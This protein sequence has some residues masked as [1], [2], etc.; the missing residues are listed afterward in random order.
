MS[1][2]TFDLTKRAWAVAAGW[3]VLTGAVI[4]WSWVSRGGPAEGD[5]RIFANYVL[6]GLVGLADI[7]LTYR[8]G[9]KLV[10]QREQAAA[11]L[12]RTNADLQDTN[13]Q[14][15]GAIAR[16]NQMAVE[17]EVASAAKSEFL[18]NMSH[19]IR[20]P[21]NAIIGMT[22][23]ALD[24]RLNEDQRDYLR[25]VK[26]SA[27]ALLTIINDILDFS[28][29]EAGKL[30]LEEAPLALRDTVY[31]A[32]RPLALRA[33]DKGLELACHIRPDV[34]DALI[35]DPIRLRQ[36]LVNL[37]GNAIKFTDTGEVVV[38]A[39][40]TAKDAA[41]ARLAL[42]V[43]DTGVGIP[44]KKR[45]LIFDAFAQADGSSTR[46]HGGTG[47]GL[48]ISRK[49]VRMMGGDISVR[50]VP[51]KGSTFTFEVQMRMDD[52]PARVEGRAGKVGL[53]GRRV[54]IVD[55]NKTNRFIL[56]EMLT[57]W[58]MQ[59]TAACGGDE[60]LERMKQ[61][62]ADGQGFELLILDGCMPGKDGLATAAAVRQMPELKDTPIVMLTSSGR[63]GEAHRRREL[64][65]LRHLTKPVR[66][67]DLLAAI[68]AAVSGEQPVSAAPE[69][70][71]QVPL[72]GLRVLLA[73]DNPTNQA[74][75]LRVLQKWG[76]R[77]TV[78]ADG[79]KA[80]EAYRS[81]S[82][83]AVLMDVQMPQMDGYEATAE[84]RRH[85]QSTGRHV[86]IVAMTAG[87]TQHDRE[88]CLQ[89]GM[90][91]YVPKPVRR[92]DL[93][94]VLAGVVQHGA[95]SALQDQPDRPD[96]G[97]RAGAMAAS[98]DVFDRREALDRVC[99]ETSVLAEVAGMFLKSSAELLAQMQAALNDADGEALARAAHAMKGSAGNL[100]AKAC[101]AAARELEAAARA[102]DLGRAQECWALL[103][104]EVA[105]L[106]PI[107]NDVAGGKV[108][109]E[110]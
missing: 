53:D 87:A 98:L 22:E 93:R 56:Q 65:V 81:E 59:V 79:Q 92:D 88:Q 109:C 68:M 83:D 8:F 15:E 60:A 64:G 106:A 31:E 72:A 51:G 28:K 50:S 80:V 78:V 23:L 3:V 38:R 62:A 85:D 2:R 47:L 13:R 105:R 46:R 7:A 17:A 20:T 41:S 10:R 73:E 30:E 37:V 57:G 99:G 48:A 44:R 14:L 49:L 5:A 63:H 25:N 101:H 102:G 90:D 32:I 110:S 71:E 104:V 27:E 11:D 103:K 77:V 24:T 107:L 82:F 19:E 96:S 58:K 52:R 95:A 18:A 70:V 4:V 39:E 76:C 42:S 89:A 74:V 29:I 26:T 61:E 108:S 34:P 9:V 12:E 1:I 100:S 6:L 45:Q 84:I 36:V 16:A 91:A 97:D 55:D 54:L 66:Q 69:P 86:T 21:M 40:C 75:A 33:H 43:Q 35:G 94:E 67:S